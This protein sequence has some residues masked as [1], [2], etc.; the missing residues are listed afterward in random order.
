MRRAFGFMCVLGM[1]AWLLCFGV[2]RCVDVAN[3][4]TPKRT[5][6]TMYDEGHSVFCAT[7][8]DGWGEALDA[9][10]CVYVPRDT[11]R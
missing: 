11:V 7:R 2:T 5:W 6:V 1:I 4:A 9:V 8:L 10:S 3:A